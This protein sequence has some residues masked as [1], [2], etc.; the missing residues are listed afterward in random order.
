MKY[1]SKDPS[2]FHEY[3][4]KQKAKGKETVRM[5][6]RLLIGNIILIALFFIVLFGVLFLVKVAPARKSTHEFELRG[7]QVS[8]GCGGESCQAVFLQ[9]RMTS[10]PP[11]FIFWQREK[12]N[13]VVSSAK[14]VL[15]KSE[16]ENNKWTSRFILSS[17]LQA[18][19]KVFVK[20]VYAVAIAQNQQ[21]QTIE[22]PEEF[23]FR[24]FP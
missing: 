18:D 12:D 5:G 8:L 22:E 23:S 3:L 24:V 15:R 6:H 13:N 14:Q 9:Q 10:Q 11:K 2:E 20:I 19:E 7:W 17:P 1:Y 16:Q 21:P 4:E